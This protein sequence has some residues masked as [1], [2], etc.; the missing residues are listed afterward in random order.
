MP[1][2][3]LEHRE[4]LPGVGGRYQVAVPDRGHRDEAEEQVLAER[5]IPCR[6]EERHAAELTAALKAKAKNMPISRYAA[7][8]RAASRVDSPPQHQMAHDGKRRDQVEQAADGEYHAELA[9][10]LVHEEAHGRDGRGQA[11]HNR[12]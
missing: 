3:R 2:H 7:T 12:R 10:R 8:P 4:C 5:A 6:A 11:Q 1:G 9:T